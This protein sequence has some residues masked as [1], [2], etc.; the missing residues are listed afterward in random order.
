MTI[1]FGVTFPERPLGTVLF[2]GMVGIHPQ[3]SSSHP[4]KV[5]ERR[6]ISDDGLPESICAF[7]SPFRSSR[8]WKRQITA[9]I[10]KV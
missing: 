6:F 3:I 1:E 5:T 10:F 9:I 7:T 4:K 2:M 8:D